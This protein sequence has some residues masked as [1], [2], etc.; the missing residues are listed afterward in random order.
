[1][2]PLQ[3]LDGYQWASAEPPLA[4]VILGLSVIGLLVFAFALP[5][6]FHVVENV[7]SRWRSNRNFSITWT[8]G[9]MIALPWAISS[10]VFSA[11]LMLFME[12]APEGGEADGCRRWRPDSRDVEFESVSHSLFPLSSKCEWVDGVS[13]ERMPHVFNGVIFVLCVTSV[14]CVILSFRDRRT[15][16]SIAG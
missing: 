12:Y 8:N 9:W 5:M 3:S 1:L 14:V 13:V 4:S 15:R 2:I 16:S 10:Y 7:R 6:T 11:L